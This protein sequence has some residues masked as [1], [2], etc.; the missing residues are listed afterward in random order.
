MDSFSIWHWLIVLGVVVAIFR[1][2]Q[3][4]SLGSDVATAIRNFKEAIHR[5]KPITFHF[6][7]G[8]A[9]VAVVCLLMGAE[10]LIA[11]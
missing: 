8:V 3:P 11:R 5:S 7:V 4:D 2:N 1:A 10:K 9:L 6:W